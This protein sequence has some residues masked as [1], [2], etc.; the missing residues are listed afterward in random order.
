MVTPSAFDVTA[1]FCVCIAFLGGC[2]HFKASS[3]ASTPLDNFLRSCSDNFLRSCHPDNFVR[4]GSGDVGFF[5]AAWTTC[6]EVLDAAADFW[7]TEDNK[8]FGGGPTGGFGA[9]LDCGLGGGPAGGFGAFLGGT[10]CEVPTLPLGFVIGFAGFAGDECVFLVSSR[11]DTS[12][13]SK[14]SGAL[15]WRSRSVV[16]S[17][18]G[19]GTGKSFTCARRSLL[20]SRAF[21]K[22]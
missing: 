7:D 5:G 13:S 2:G 16:D 11:S 6:D 20:N 4:S 9:F 3:A 14:I 17:F 10:L 19:L 22:P 18:K 15:C 1:R 8:D 21:S 12:P